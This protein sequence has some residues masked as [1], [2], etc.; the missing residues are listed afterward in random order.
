MS[1]GN[2]GNGGSGGDGGDGGH[3]VAGRSGGKLGEIVL[4]RRSITSVV[5]AAGPR[6]AVHLHSCGPSRVV[7]PPLPTGGFFLQ[8]W[9]VREL[10]EQGMWAAPHY[11]S[12]APPTF[13]LRDALVH[14][15]AG[16]LGVGD[17]A[18][19][20]SLA[21]TSCGQHRYQELQRAIAISPTEIVKLPGIHISLLAG[22]AQEY[23][24]AVLDGLARLVSVPENVV[25][26]A[27]GL[28]VPRGAMAQRD[29]LELM[30]L[31]P[32]LAIREVS[33]G[34][35]L[36]VETLIYPLSVTGEAAYHPCVIDFFRRISANVARAP[37]PLPERFY[38]DL[39]EAGLRPLRNEAALI[40]ALSREG[41]VPVRLSEFGLQDQIRLFRHAR[42]IVAPHGGPLTN[43]GFA[44]PGCRVIELLMDAAVDWSFRNLAALMDLSYDCVI[45]RARRPWPDLGSGVD[46]TPWEISINH[47]IAAIAHTETQAAKAA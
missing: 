18:I 2:G 19:E 16:I 8:L 23:R 37:R 36:V 22:G 31:L 29:L 33:P 26:A 14:G 1:G 32:T 28:L 4:R 40:E 12:F 5:E 7:V 21:H 39:R 30:D 3:G 17:M 9:A 27:N 47:V 6:R 34:E 11:D 10:P 15:P 45:G 43:L 35:T 25:A 44:R 38:I 24:H 42:L 41:I 46:R 20:E 13:L